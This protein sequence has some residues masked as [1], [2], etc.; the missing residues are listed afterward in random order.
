MIHHH[1]G[2][3]YEANPAVTDEKCPWLV[4]RIRK[5]NLCDDCLTGFSSDQ[6]AERA[7]KII[8]PS[9]FK[10]YWI[11][12]HPCQGVAAVSKSRV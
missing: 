5:T 4:V 9:A 10:Q 3:A 12:E 7:G 8:P 6:R 1:G 11:K 2:V